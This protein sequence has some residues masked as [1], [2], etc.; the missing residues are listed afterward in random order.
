MLHLEKWFYHSYE[1]A[2]GSSRSSESSTR[3]RSLPSPQRGCRAGDPD[4]LP[5]LVQRVSWQARLFAIVEDRTYAA[6][7]SAI[8]LTALTISESA[9]IFRRAR[10]GL[11]CLRNNVSLR[12]LANSLCAHCGGV[13]FERKARRGFA[14]RRKAYGLPAGTSLCTSQTFVRNAARSC[15]ACNGISG[16]AGDFATS[17]RVV[18]GKLGS[19]RRC[20]RRWHLSLPA[21]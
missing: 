5:L 10:G 2:S 18:C 20:M 14:R 11:S 21:M 13:G 17:V 1:T 16:R 12:A 15:F 4:P 7:S 8:T 19:F 6:T 9:V 3:T